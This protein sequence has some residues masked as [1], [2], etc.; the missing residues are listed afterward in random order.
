MTSVGNVF[1]TNFKIMKQ[2]HTGICITLGLGSGGCNIVNFFKKISD[3]FSIWWEKLNFG[4]K[5]GDRR[6]LFPALH[7]NTTETI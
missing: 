1:W 2:L 6:P 3:Q 4:W 7:D 5:T